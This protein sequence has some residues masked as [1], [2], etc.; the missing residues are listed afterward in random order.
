MVE[1]IFLVLVPVIGTYTGFEL[2]CIGMGSIFS[3]IYVVVLSI[4]IANAS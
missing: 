2:T 3:A 1:S 4:W